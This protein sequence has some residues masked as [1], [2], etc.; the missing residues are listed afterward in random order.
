MQNTF[1]NKV[2]VIGGITGG[3][4]SEL[5][6]QLSA[7]GATV[8]GFSRNGGSSEFGTVTQCDASDPTQLD[9]YFD[10]VL[11]E[12]GK[13]DGYAHALGSIFLKPAH[14]TSPDDWFATLQQNLSSGFFALRALTKRMQSAGYGNIVFFSSVAAQVGISNHEAIAA[15]KGGLEAMVRSAAATYAGR[16]LRINAIAPSLT[17]TPMG[18][19]LLASEQAR[20]HSCK[21]HPLGE[22]AKA[23]DVASLATWLLSDAAKMVTGQTYVMDGGLSAIVPKPR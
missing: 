23:V 9:S 18:Q 1:S 14:L 21:M 15:A 13:I 7:A 10:G 6:E 17:D 22:I 20:Q 16:G 5:A 2:I 3:I 19:P 12:H 11:A 8:T 4:G